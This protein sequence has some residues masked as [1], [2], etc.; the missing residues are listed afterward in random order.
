MPQTRLSAEADVFVELSVRW[1]IAS[2]RTL[3]CPDATHTAIV[4]K[5]GVWARMWHGLHR[6]TKRSGWIG[7][8]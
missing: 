4:R 5:T 3:K 7:S 1:T 6:N 8:T 2:G